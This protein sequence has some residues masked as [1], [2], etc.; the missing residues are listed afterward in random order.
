MNQPSRKSM[1]IFAITRHGVATAQTL[2]DHYPGA[3]LY[4][5]KKFIKQAPE[6]AIELPLPFSPI[7]GD[8]FPQYD[9]HIFIISVGAVVRMIAPHL[10]SKKVDPAVLCIDDSSRYVVCL[11]SGHVGRGNQFT[12]DVAEK[13]GSEPVVTTASDRLGTLTVDILGRE[14]G[15]VL[16]DQ[17]F[18]VTRGCAAVVNE[19]PVA[20]IQE[21]GEP[22]F[23]PLEKELPKN[24]SYQTSTIGLSAKDYGVLLWVTDRLLAA[25]EQELQAEAVIY[26]PKSLVVGIGCDKNT[27][28]ETLRE[29]LIHWFRKEGLSLKCI[30][31][32]ASIDLKAE[33][34]GILALAQNFGVEFLTYKAGVL[35]GVE[36]IENPS[37]V[38]RKHV[39][40]AA[41]A[42]AAALKEAGASQLLVAKRKYKKESEPFN[43]TL[44]VAR[45][46][47]EPRAARGATPIMETGV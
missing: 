7:L 14:L 5:S 42:E 32:F 3:D 27:P 8:L 46:P 23:W 16:D 34:P 26:R 24:V 19:E 25:H 15:W 11:L 40:C 36:G 20:F 39:G 44:A 33:E 21:T 41:V 12:L 29:G 9:C 17:D 1:A 43:M 4:V 45:L 47:Y 35:D 28:F 30:K 10:K 38:V 37:E 18:N 6:G 22:T 31:A 13:L 2:L